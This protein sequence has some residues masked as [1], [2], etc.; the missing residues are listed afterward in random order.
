MRNVLD[1]LDIYVIIL[2][3]WFYLLFS[4]ELL[5]I[6]GFMFSK[7]GVEFPVKILNMI[8]SNVFRGKSKLEEWLQNIG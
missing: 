8:F 4:E 1:I 6:F 2:M 3:K 7:E 5:G